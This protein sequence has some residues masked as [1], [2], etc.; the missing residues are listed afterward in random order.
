MFAFDLV[1]P[2]MGLGM[3]LLLALLLATD[4]L[5]SDLSVSRWQD[6]AWLAWAGMLA[7]LIHQ[8]EEHGID[9]QGAVY[10]FRTDACRNFGFSDI[11][12]CPIPFS[13]ITAVNISAVWL[14]GPA[15][16]LLGR[17]RPE[18]A[19]AFFAIPFV[20]AFA[21]IVPAMAQGAYNAGM[22]TGIVLF[23]PLSLWTF[24]VAVTRYR[25][26][27]RAVIGTTA[28]GIMFHAI[29]M[30]SLAAFVGG[31]I[32]VPVLDTIQ[33]INPAIILLIVARFRRRTASLV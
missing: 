9:A 3:A 15:T 20:N 7:Y 6:L 4:A 32:G 23:L 14:F 25:L 12:A 33:V 24:R 11:H 31:H 10:A 19:L 18:L 13:F 29:L 16:A 22:L 17:R 8:F 26:G 30:G 2:Y 21:H 27:W 1:W 28:A 5:R